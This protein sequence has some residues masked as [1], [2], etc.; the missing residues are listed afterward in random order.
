MQSAQ[1][2]INPYTIRGGV[3][4]ILE[5]SRLFSA[6]IINNQPMGP[7]TLDTTNL[8]NEEWQALD[9]LRCEYFQTC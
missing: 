8:S 4:T 1:Y 6:P 2:A 5:L 7:I 9:E 3:S